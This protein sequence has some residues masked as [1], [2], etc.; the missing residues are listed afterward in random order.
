MIAIYTRT[1]AYNAVLNSGHRDRFANDAEFNAAVV[2]VWQAARNGQIEARE[3]DAICDQIVEANADLT[4][5]EIAIDEG[6]D[7][8]ADRSRA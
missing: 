1:D 5:E 3:F 7:A 6:I 8:E 2:A 4:A